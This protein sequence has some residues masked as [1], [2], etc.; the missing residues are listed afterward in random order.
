MAGVPC[1]LLLAPGA[2]RP[3]VG[4][5]APSA[6]SPCQLIRSTLDSTENRIWLSSTGWCGQRTWRTFFQCL[7]VALAIPVVRFMHD[8]KELLHLQRPSEIRSFY[9]DL[10]AYRPLREYHIQHVVDACYYLALHQLV[11]ICKYFRDIKVFRPFVHKELLNYYDQDHLRRVLE[12]P[13]H[14]FIFDARKHVYSN[15]IPKT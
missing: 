11:I 15:W 4:S 5:W 12:M 6:L 14:V 13:A 9:R 1:L 7:S 8:L 10:F 3:G 2:F